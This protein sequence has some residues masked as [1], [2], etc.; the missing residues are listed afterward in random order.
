MS[1]T[2]PRYLDPDMIERC[3][4]FWEREPTDRPL[5]GVLVNRMHPL[6]HYPLKN[7]R[8]RLQPDDLTVESFLADCRRRHQANLATGGDTVFVAYPTI[9]FPW[10]AALLGCPVRYRGTSAW[11]ERYPGDWT[12]YSV[13]NVPWDGG[14]LARMREM[15]C[16]AI[17]M[18]ADQFPVGP[19]HLHGVID[20]AAAMIGAEELCLAMYEAPGE[21]ARLLDVIAE[22]WSRVAKDQFQQLPSYAGGYFNGNQ[23]LWAPGPTMFVPSDAVAL[24]SPDAVE[25]WVIPRVRRTLEGM[26]YCIAHTHSTYLHGL[27]AFLEIDSLRAVQVGMDATG[28][29]VSDLVRT[30]REIQRQKALIIAIVVAD[31]QQAARDASTAMEALSPEGLCIL[32]YLP[33]AAAGEE[34]LSH[35]P[36]VR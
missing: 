36:A 26:P 20:V 23:P 32:S 33:T 35:F 16:A 5:L 11:A 22:V 3:R 4:R 1:V 19:C 12:A 14:W 10:L 2:R 31:P 29:P 15:T 17:E 28:P 24:I 18:G 27:R 34:F 21:L 25:T 8:S 13:D 6:T 7:A 9:G 30:L